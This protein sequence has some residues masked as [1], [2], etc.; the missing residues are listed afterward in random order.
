MVAGGGFFFAD[1]KYGKKKI[2]KISNE[3][4]AAIDD[5]KSRPTI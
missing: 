2:Q 3:F 5:G 1:R 4:T